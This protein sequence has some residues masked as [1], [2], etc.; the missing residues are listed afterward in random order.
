MKLKYKM[1]VSVYYGFGVPPSPAPYTRTGHWS[2]LSRQSLHSFIRCP[3]LKGTT[4]FSLEC[5]QIQIFQEH[6][7]CSSHLG[8]RPT[9]STVK[10]SWQQLQVLWHWYSPLAY[11]LEVLQTRHW[12]AKIGTKLLFILSH[13]KKNAEAHKLRL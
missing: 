10:W 2:I 9:F 4:S 7:F 11:M 1:S 6:F 3:Q 13:V 5:A 8:Q 12:D